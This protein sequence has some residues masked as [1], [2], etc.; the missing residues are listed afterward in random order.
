MI[1]GK[2]SEPITIGNFTVHSVE[3]LLMYARY[4]YDQYMRIVTRIDEEFRWRFKNKSK[5]EIASLEKLQEKNRKEASKIQ[6]YKNQILK[7]KFRNKQIGDKY[8][9]IK[10]KHDNAIE[11]LD[12]IVLLKIADL[13]S[14]YFPITIGCTIIKDAE[15]LISYAKRTHSIADYQ[16]KIIKQLLAEYFKNKK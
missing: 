2:F 11:I 4:L 8:R 15:E 1:L 3:G 12:K 6:Y 13:G 16:S 14:K 10:N 9:I 7:Q 5:D